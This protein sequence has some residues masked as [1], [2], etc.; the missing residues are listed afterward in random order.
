MLFSSFHDWDFVGL[1]LIEF[2]PNPL[3]IQRIS[4]FLNFTSKFTAMK[5]LFVFIICL[6][7]AS[8]SMAQ[9]PDSPGDT[10]GIWSVINFEEPSPYFHI[11]QSPG[12]IWQVGEPQKTFFNSAWSVPNAIVTDTFNAY[13]P[14]NLSTFDLYVGAFNMGG[15]W[16]GLYP[17]DIFIDIRH[18]FDSDTLA[19]GGFITVSWDKGQTFRNIISDTAYYTY[20]YGLSPMMN[21]GFFGA[22]TGMYTS[23]N[24]LS[25]GEPGFS[26]NSGGWAHT[27]FAWF[28]LPMKEKM[29]YPPDTMI[30]RFNFF[31]DGNN[32]SKE[33]WMIDDI[34]IFSIDLGS[35]IGDHGESNAGIR[36]YPNPVT[37]NAFVRLNETYDDVTYSLS[38]MTGRICAEGSPGKCS[39][40]SISRGGLSPGVYILK[41]NADSGLNATTR[42]VI[43]N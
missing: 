32:S 29:D 16:Y 21:T 5:K 20:M 42:I 28:M 9:L 27:C 30:V 17:Y 33:G 22:N 19:D 18:K 14:N 40:F 39:S 31:S 4:K 8:L 34:R 12:N 3:K 1:K 15:E 37:S 23:Q 24:L 11:N 10:I 6:T 7:T 41:V 35:G 26:G 25:N 36:I 43:A 13:P 2:I 38:D